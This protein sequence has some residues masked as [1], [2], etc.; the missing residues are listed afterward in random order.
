[1]ALPLKTSVTHCK[2]SLLGRATKQRANTSFEGNIKSDI[3]FLFRFKPPD[4]YMELI[5]KVLMKEGF[6]K[7]NSAFGYCQGCVPFRYK[8]SEY[9]AS[10]LECKKKNVAPQ[11][12]KMKPSI[13]VTEGYALKTIVERA[14]IKVNAFYN[15]VING[16]K[17]ESV[18]YSPEF[19]SWIIPLP[20]YDMWV[21]IRSRDK[22]K[23][24]REI[25]DLGEEEEVGEDALWDVLYSDSEEIRN[26]GKIF[27]NFYS[28]FVTIQL[29]N[30]SNYLKKPRTVNIDKYEKK[31]VDDP[32]SF[33]SQYI[34]QNIE[35]SLDLETTGLKF[36][37]HDIF[38]LL[39]SFDGKTGYY[40]PWEKIDINILNEFIRGKKLITANGKFDILFLW[41]K[42]VTNASLYFDVNYAG[43][44][45]NSNRSNGLKEQTYY[46]TLFG[47]YDNALDEYKSKYKIKN[48]SDIP[49]EVMMEYAVS[50]AIMTYRLKS[51]YVSHFDRKQLNFF[52]NTYMP[53]ANLVAKMEYEGLRVDLDYLKVYRKRLLKELEG[54]EKEIRDIYP[55]IKNLAST[56]DVRKML[57]SDLGA[58]VKIYTDK[59]Q[60][61]VG[62]EALSIW[63][64][65]QDEKI[66]KISSLMLQ[67][68]MKT[69][70]VTSYVADGLK[71]HS[72]PNKILESDLDIDIIEGEDTREYSA[73]EA[74]I[75]QNTDE[76][77]MLHSSF[78][79]Q[80][81]NVFRLSS[82]SP[83]IQNIAIKSNPDIRYLFP[84]RKGYRLAEVDYSG[85]HFRIMAMYSR[86]RSMCEM[87][88]SDNPDDR[89]L[90]SK[91]AASVFTDY[92]VREFRERMVSGSKEEIWLLKNYRQNA[93]ACNFGFLY[94]SLPFSFAR[95]ILMLPPPDG[96]DEKMAL[97]YMEKNNLVIDPLE[98]MNPRTDDKT[99]IYYACAVDIR[100][101]FFAEYTGVWEWL[102]QSR[103]DGKKKGYVETL[104]GVKVYLPEY[105]FDFCESVEKK[106]SGLRNDVVN[107]PI[108]ATE[109]NI[110]QKAML[111]LD[112]FFVKERLDIKIVNQVHDS[113]LL[114]IKENLITDE[115]AN[116]IKE[117][118]EHPLPEYGGIKL[119][120]EAEHFPYWG[121]SPDKKSKDAAVSW[122]G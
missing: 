109:A 58:E 13:I 22:F 40:I 33:L 68:R 73:R 29:R 3:L 20:P 76:N 72:I 11:I 30:A 113:V 39:L 110:M 51:F 114:E 71:K 27:D 75:I 6:T 9:I 7:K 35:M 118:M 91:T 95:N 61:S 42:G 54:I 38:C 107:Y 60:P 59:N 21:G 67:H 102:L 48:Y 62:D 26:L 101:K 44:M 37:K 69:K 19:N 116:K 36:F 55:N 64:N 16:K 98:D 90:H 14:N 5:K 47:G 12:H 100:R 8:S 97:D 28:W 31:Y 103:I 41:K 78:N 10:I 50:D 66:K 46:H 115:V 105:K 111:R 88:S 57:V 83:N 120:V 92:D 17:F 106:Y 1:M 49:Y 74:T 81:V 82:T 23:L 70:L 56:E 52:L 117:I 99:K 122:I 80:R 25:S 77:S 121:G 96:W 79:F 112:S 65:S 2:C 43:H 86:D 53:L 93:K 45:F 18:F 4:H 24:R 108:I 87:F 85:F 94:G 104:F 15:C 84:A 119:D 63:A 34:G 89:D 32:N